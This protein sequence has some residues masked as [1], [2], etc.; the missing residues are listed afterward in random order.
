MDV[1]LWHRRRQRR[2]PA[3]PWSICCANRPASFWSSLVRFSHLA[4]GGIVW[5]RQTTPLPLYHFF[6]KW[7]IG[8]GLVCRRKSTGGRV[9]KN[10]TS[11]QEVCAL[12]KSPQN[13]HP[14]NLVLTPGCR[15]CVFAH[16][17]TH[18]WEAGFATSLSPVSFASQNSR[19][20]SQ[21]E[22]K[23]QCKVVKNH[24]K[25]WILFTCLGFSAQKSFPCNV[26]NHQ[27]TLDN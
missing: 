8:R 15:E 26:K 3:S 23:W 16:A 6:K 9:V 7:Y 24:Q 14:R 2:R 4:V 21:R 18:W 25:T 27:K 1:R 22:K 19:F 11:L 5:L 13:P 20:F 12:L 17:K 10:P